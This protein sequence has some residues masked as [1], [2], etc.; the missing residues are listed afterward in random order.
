MTAWA[1]SSVVFL[2][3]WIWYS[4]RAAWTGADAGASWVDKLVRIKSRPWTWLDGLLFGGSVV[5][6]AMWALADPTGTF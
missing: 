5:S 4:I 6:I 2:V 1:M 3:G